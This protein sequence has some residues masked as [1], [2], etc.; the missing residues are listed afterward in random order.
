MKK[1]FTAAIVMAV[2]LFTSTARA[3]VK[4]GYISV[5]NMVSLMPEALSLDSI[6]GHFQS[7][8]LNPKYAEIV[9]LYKYKDSIIRDT[10]HKAPE[11][12]RK[13]LAAE[14]PTLIYQIQNWDQIS[15]RATENKQN[16][17]LAPAYRK[18]YDAIK[19]VAKE[20]GYSHVANREAFLL[21]PDGDDMTLAVA[22][23]LKVK[24][25]AQMPIGIR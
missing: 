19:L 22:A 12:V 14:L 9:T 10:V 11:S 17:V 23:K 21:A 16:A 4:I 15:Q 18:V 2:L 13:Q 7:D 5:D 25:P 3:Q 6:L 1:L 8:T 24:V 20:K